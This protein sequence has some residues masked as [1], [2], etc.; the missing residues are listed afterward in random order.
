MTVRQHRSKLRRQTSGGGF[1]LIELITVIVLAAILAGVA[2]P[3]LSSISDTRE[4]FGGK[5]LLR[6]MTYARQRAVATG[7]RT[8]VVFDTAAETWS[9][10]VED[11]ASPGRVGATALTDPSTGGAFVTTMGVDVFVGVGITSAVFDGDDE[12][13]FDW[14]GRALNSSENL[15]TAKGTATLSGGQSVT[16]EIDTGYIEYVP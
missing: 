15:L 8:W 5:Q 3:A 7:T 1:T 6:D 11:P 14:L 10:L 12:V 13:G 16:V 4:T 2:A 9:I